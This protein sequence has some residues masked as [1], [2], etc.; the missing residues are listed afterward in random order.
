M[1]SVCAGPQTSERVA[2]GSESVKRI[3]VRTPAEAPKCPTASQSSKNRCTE[4][5]GTGSHQTQLK[6]CDLGSRAHCPR[7]HSGVRGLDAHPGRGCPTG[8]L[9][10]QCPWLREAVVQPCAGEARPELTQNQ[11]GAGPRS[12]A[13]HTQ[14]SHPSS[15][16]R[17][18]F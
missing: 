17:T 8:Y 16:P 13:S 6:A 11:G 4:L 5:I 2:S 1:V 14:S 7:S 10:S 18:S 15:I 3:S 9:P 12:S